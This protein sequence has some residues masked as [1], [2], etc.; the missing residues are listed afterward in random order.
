M[1]LFHTGELKMTNW[2]G[3]DPDTVWELKV[4]SNFAE[5]ALFS[6]FTAIRFYKEPSRDMELRA[7]YERNPRPMLDEILRRILSNKTFQDLYRF[8]E[9]AF[10]TVFDGYFCDLDGRNEDC[11]LAQLGL[12][13]NP[14]VTDQQTGRRS[15][16]ITQ[17]PSGL[18]RFGYADVF[19]AALQRIHPGRTLVIELKVVSVWNLFLAIYEDENLC[20]TKVEGGPRDPPN[21]FRKNVMEMVEKVDNATIQ[22]LRATSYGY[23]TARGVNTQTIG[24]ML[25]DAAIQLNSYTSAVVNGKADNGTN[26]KG[27]TSAERRIVVRNSDSPDEVL[28]LIVCFIGHRIIAVPLEPQVQNKQYTY[29]VVPRWRKNWKG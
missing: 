5:Y 14:S 11:Y 25:D 21:T 19:I 1:L 2:P 15:G 6:S 7:L 27:I 10:Q 20:R 12:L 16:A 18:G 29:D 23:K 9:L 22:Q 28:G 26:K 24:A 17:G 4:A 8:T 3:I 13:T